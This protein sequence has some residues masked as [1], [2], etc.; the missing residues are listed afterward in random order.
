MEPD[1]TLCNIA[2]TPICIA[3]QQ[4]LEDTEINLQGSIEYEVQST[5]SED[6]T[7]KIRD[8]FLT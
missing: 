2:F 4:E 3:D 1:K 6:A 7:S 8:P 5:F